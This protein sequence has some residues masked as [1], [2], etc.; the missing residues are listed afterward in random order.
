[1]PL[2]N[3]HW[4]LLYRADLLEQ[5][6][7]A[8]PRTWTQWDE[9]IEKIRKAD[10]PVPVEDRVVLPLAENWAAHTFLQRCAA[11][12]R[13]R[14]KL[15]TVFDRSS[16]KP[17]IDQA[18]FVEAL[19]DLKRQAGS[20]DLSLT[21]ADAWQQMLD[22]Q[23]VMTIAWPTNMQSDEVANESDIAESISI[24]SIPGANRWFDLQAAKWFEREAADAEQSVDYFGFAGL[25]GSVSS[26]SRHA[27]SA[28][29]FLQWLS[30][31]PI[32]STV[33]NGS[34][35]SGPFRKSQL[36]SASRWSGSQL[37]PAA[38]DSMAE[39][40]RAAHNNPVAFVFPRVPGYSDYIRSLD[41]H[42]RKCLAGKSTAA[43]SLKSAAEEWE[44]ITERIGR[45]EQT[46]NLRRVNGL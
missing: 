34:Q 18:P 37:T 23:L 44:A 38:G 32:S 36:K 43:E 13:Q 11:T 3:P 16:M 1:M 22:G 10:L 17:L 5:A 26:E 19:S 4:M 2:A 12:I 30:S 41:K 25:V 35:Q 39:Q 24:A 45:M 29:Q 8:V 46:A 40:I 20:L 7:V 15:S 21:P 14:G 33:L 27:S 31:S 9:A 28:F 42:V 6:N